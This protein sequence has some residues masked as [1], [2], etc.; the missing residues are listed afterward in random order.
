M[1]DDVTST[2]SSTVQPTE[3]SSVTDD[4][5]NDSRPVT[6]ERPD[7][8][9]ENAVGEFSRKF[10]RLEQRLDS[11]A[12]AMVQ[13]QRPSGEQPTAYTDDDLWRLAQQGD[14]AAFDL[15]MQRVAA[16]TSHTQIQQN[17]H[18]QLIDGQLATLAQKYPVLNDTS[19]PLTQTV[20][21]AYQIMVQQGYQPGKVTLLDAI[22]TAIA[23][24]PDLVAELQ[25]QSTVV[26]DAPRRSAAEVA[27]AGQTAAA[28]RNPPPPAPRTKARPMTPDEI[29]LAKRMGLD[30][31]KAAQS[32]E[33]FLKRREE[34]VSGI[35]AVGL[36]VKEED[37]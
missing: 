28:H 25:G 12:Q 7:R 26:R 18:V 35:G 21:Q 29:A 14:R 16:R 19:H 4:R 6:T 23:D 11:I 20:Q 3:S 32:K 31:A 17:R 36:H 24:R 22:K 33:R 13:P 27:Q 37:L 9:I 10:A 34:G 15:Y 8:P 30:P 1:P 2:E 5:E